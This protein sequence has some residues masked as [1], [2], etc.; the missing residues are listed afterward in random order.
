[1]VE[2]Q[3]QAESLYFIPCIKNAF[4]YKSLNIL[5]VFFSSK[6]QL[7]QLANSVDAI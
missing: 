3:L 6:K 4:I 1:M 2:N 7:K 5:N